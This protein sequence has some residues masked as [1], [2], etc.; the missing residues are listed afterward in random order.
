[1]D[2][3]ER[4]RVAHLLWAIWGRVY[5]AIFDFRNGDMTY[6]EVKKYIKEVVDKMD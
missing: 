2:L 5:V 3:A 1:M 4:G 6:E